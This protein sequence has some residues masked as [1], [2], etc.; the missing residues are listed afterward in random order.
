MYKQGNENEIFSELFI[1][2]LSEKLGFVTAHYEKDGDY[3]RSLDFTDGASVNYE[4]IYSLVGEDEDYKN[5]FETLI[6]L[7]EDLAKQYLILIWMDTISFIWIDT[8]KT[9]DF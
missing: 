6:G 9:L 1:C 8:H 2:K 3:I 4:P 7:S 5:C